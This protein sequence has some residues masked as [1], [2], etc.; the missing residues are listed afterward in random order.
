MTAGPR[1]TRVAAGLWVLF[2]AVITLLVAFQPYRRTV[3]PVYHE[4]VAD[5]AAGRDLY[6]PGKR[7]H[8]LPQ[9]ALAFAPLAALPRPWAEVPWRWL[10]LGLYLSAALALSRRLGPGTFPWI[11]FLMIPAALSAARSG[12]TNLALAAAFVHAALAWEAGRWTRAAA[13]LLTAVVL[14]PIALVMLLL[15]AVVR[16]PL[17]FRLAIGAAGL[18]ILPYAFQD[19]GYLH[20]QYRRAFESWTAWSATAEHRF[21]DLA[22]LLRTAGLAVAPPVLT[23]VRVAAAV[24]TL[25]LWWRASREGEPD[26]ALHLLGLSTSYL[27]LF[28]PMTETNSYVLLA[29]ALAAWAVGRARAERPVHVGLAAL[30]FGLGVDSYGNPIHPW[31]NLWLKAVLATVFYLWLAAGILRRRAQGAMPGSV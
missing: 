3:T 13:W 29:P 21:C 28:N 14:K 25:G 18:A 6:A 8:Y 20:E 7:F 12:Q 30:A 16:V 27:M 10:G 9:F 26:R 31:T 5:F 11:S 22:G 2:F 4:A 17:A 19:A 23:A 15:A 24:L 1:L